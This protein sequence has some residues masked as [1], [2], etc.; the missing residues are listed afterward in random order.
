MSPVNGVGVNLGGQPGGAGSMQHA[1]PNA[2][3][4]SLNGGPGS[5]N[6]AIGAAGNP[7]NHMSNGFIPSFVPHSAVAVGANSHGNTTN[8]SASL[9]ANHT[10]II[11][12][13]LGT[14]QQG[15]GGLSQQ[16]LVGVPGIDCDGVMGAGEDRNSAGVS[17][18]L[19]AASQFPSASGDQVSLYSLHSR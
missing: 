8:S 9:S 13:D 10:G 5:L 16:H 1:G 2:A 11:S 19:P 4:P 14:M 12:K 18:H 15:Y 3:A 6:P 7:L 17:S